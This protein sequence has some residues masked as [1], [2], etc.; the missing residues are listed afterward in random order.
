MNPVFV[1]LV[2]LCAVILWFLLSFVFYPF[3]RL[4]YRIWKEAIDEMNRDD[5]PKKKKRRK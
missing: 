1:I 4:L 5:K 3:G 2:L